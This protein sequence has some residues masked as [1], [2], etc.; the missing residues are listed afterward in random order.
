MRLRF[1]VSAVV[2]GV[3]LLGAS[4]GDSTPTDDP[5]PDRDSDQ[6]QAADSDAPTLEVVQR[7][8]GDE[9]GEVLR[10]V[11]MRDD[12]ALGSEFKVVRFEVQVVDTSIQDCGA[13]FSLDLRDQ[14]RMGFVECEEIRAA[15]LMS[16]PPPDHATLEAIGCREYESV[17][18]DQDCSLDASVGVAQIDFGSEALLEVTT[19]MTRTEW[20]GGIYREIGLGICSYVLHF[21]WTGADWELVDER[22]TQ[23]VSSC[24]GGNTTVT[25]TPAPINDSAEGFR[26]AVVTPS[27]A[28]DLAFTQSMVDAVNSIEGAEVSVTDGMFVVDDAAVAIRDY[29]SDGFDLVIAHGS[30][31]G[32]SL[33]EIA[34][35]F[36]E[37]SFAWGTAANT[38]GLPNVFSY[39]AASDQGGTVMGKMA[40]ALSQTANVGV[41]GP[42]EVGDAELY[43]DGF[44]AGVLSQNGN[45][46]VNINYIDSFSDVALASEAAL[47]LIGAG[48]DVLSGTSQMTIGAVG[49]AKTEGVLWFGTQSNQT[50]LAPE[51]VVASQVYHWEHMLEDMIN[52]VQDGT[53]GGELYV[54]T[55]A[56]DGLVIEYNEDFD[57]PDDVKDIAED[58][59][60]TFK[61]Q[62]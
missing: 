62:G 57:L 41:V 21:R 3:A 45:A 55:F 59:I 18:P 22:L 17:F 23:E 47:S 36:P 49:V 50:S 6:V 37:V 60:Q 42:I 9:S 15:D 13:E 44:E 54:I 32:G 16:I 20:G 10:I 33:Q 2:I 5:A 53:L 30:Q 35:D 38:Y 12:E 58:A 14:W 43:V 7:E 29:A 46:T 27:A 61:D 19:A 39:E 1:A 25:T 34:P 31:Y 40:A 56:N 24:T 28:N 11:S 52:K 51:I 4:C 8:W 26:I 48:A